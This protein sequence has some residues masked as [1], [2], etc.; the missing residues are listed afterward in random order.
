MKRLTIAIVVFLIPCSAFATAQ[1]GDKLVYKTETVEIFSNPLESYF[2]EK[3]PRPGHLFTFKCTAC[4]RGYVATWKIEDGYL[5]L[6]KIVEGS[7]SKDAKE[8]LISE[9]FPQQ[10]APVKA[11]WFTGTLRAPQGEPLLYVHMGYGSVYEKELMISIKEGRVLSEVIVDNTKIKLPSGHD[12]S[13]DEMRK[14]GEW[15][16]STKK[17]KP[18]TNKVPGAQ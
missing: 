18:K 1:L 2:N 17:E 9:I 14:L 7:C 8:I 13:L 12:R 4:W 3:N 6:T 5:Y 15:E 16:K 11:L 10:T